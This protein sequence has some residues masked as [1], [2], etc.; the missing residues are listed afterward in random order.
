M[1]IDNVVVRLEA[2]KEW[3]VR[4]LPSNFTGVISDCKLAGTI[5]KEGSKLYL[6]DVKGNLVAVSKTLKDLSAAISGL[7]V[8][9]PKADPEADTVRLETGYHAYTQCST[10]DKL[11]SRCSMEPY[12]CV[13]SDCSRTD[14][15]PKYT[16]TYAQRMKDKE[17]LKQNLLQPVDE[18]KADPV[19]APVEPEGALKNDEYAT[20]ETNYDTKETIAYNEKLPVA[21]I[22]KTAEHKWLVKEYY[23]GK[24]IDIF[25]TLGVVDSWIKCNMYNIFMKAC[26][27]LRKMKIDENGN[28]Y[29]ITCIG[30]AHHDCRII[31]A[32]NQPGY[33]RCNMND[34]LLTQGFPCFKPKVLPEFIQ[35]ESLEEPKE[36]KK[37]YPKGLI[38]TCKYCK[39][40]SEDYITR[41]TKKG[42]YKMHGCDNCRCIYP[43]LQHFEDKEAPK[44]EPK[45]NLEDARRAL[46]NAIGEYVDKINTAL[47]E[48]H[49]MEE[50]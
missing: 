5:V 4:A 23:S 48:L 30:C 21:R 34:C 40:L 1:T 35:K 11:E 22:I 14:G 44:E 50:E 12:G 18:P 17:S 41:M 27:F 6:S 43:S 7:K 37:E 46:L 47:E 16:P 28:S 2:G 19:V 15:F 29:Y 10:C 20:Y 9:E 3:E 39:H 25:P 33:G 26:D 24:Q 49:N 36:E 31:P 42:H 13:A 8:E 32:S 45:D 38:D